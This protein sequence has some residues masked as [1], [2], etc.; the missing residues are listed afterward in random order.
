MEYENK[1]AS[2]GIAGAGLG[3]GIAGTAL[4]LGFLNGGC[5]NGLFGLG[6]NNCCSENHMVDRYEAA[7]SARIAELETEVK[8]RDANIYTDSKILE[9]YKYFD[10]EVKDIRGSLAAQAVMNQKT[11]D[12]FDMVRNDMICCKNEL[13]S[14]IA[15]ERDDR[16][17]ADNSIVTYANAT[18]YPKMVA[19]VTTGT[20]TTAQAV[21]NPL[22]NCGC[23][24]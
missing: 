4:G 23:C 8:L 15:R 14:A 22:P 9:V 17:C 6:N 1:Y 20:E 21:Y 18:F 7:Q 11:A 2:K 12:A 10:G 3:L 24:R 19:A 5:G 13:Y 16:C